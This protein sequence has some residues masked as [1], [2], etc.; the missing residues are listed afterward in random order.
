MTIY[1][2]WKKK[3][4]N[5]RIPTGTGVMIGFTP[6]LI[7]VIVGVWAVTGQDRWEVAGRG[8]TETPG[9]C[10]VVDKGQRTTRRCIAQGPSPRDEHLEPEPESTSKNCR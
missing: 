10:R 7:S 3:K 2:G 5:R 8:R 1:V 4:E 9:R 6:Y